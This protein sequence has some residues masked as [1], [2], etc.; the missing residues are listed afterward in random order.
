[1][2]ENVRGDAARAA[3]HAGVTIGIS[4]R[5]GFAGWLAAGA[6]QLG[7]AKAALGEAQEAIGL[8][9][10]TLPAWQGSG[11]ETTSSYF[12]SGLAEGYRAAGQDG[13]ALEVVAQGLEH[14]QRLGEHWYDAELY[15]LR[16]ELL[17]R[18]EDT[19]AQAAAEFQRAIEVA[20]SQGARLFELRAAI[21]LARTLEGTAAGSRELL[22]KALA[23]YQ[24]AQDSLERRQAA[25]LLE[26]L[27]V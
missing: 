22:H 16:G 9:G 7:K 25:A 14:A 4:Q 11:A 15:R 26:A 1:M 5:H 21:S 13:Q 3:H 18:R 20:R 10:N 12:L 19:R 27:P 23:G 8:V 17:A 24:G 6:M 2:F